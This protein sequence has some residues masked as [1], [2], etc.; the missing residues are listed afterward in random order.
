MIDVIQTQ[1]A[2]NA[3]CGEATQMP[4]V[5]FDTEFERIRTYY[6]RLCLIQMSTPDVTVCVDPLAELDFSPLFELLSNPGVIK[7]FHAARQDLEVLHT[8]FG[9]SISSIFDT[10]IAAQLCGY[11][12]QIAYAELAKNVCEIDLPKQYTRT[13]WSRRPLS[14]AEVKYALDDARYLGP[15]YL[16]LK[17]RLERLGRGGWVRE[18]CEW[19]TSP[20]ILASSPAGAIKKIQSGSRGLPRIEQ[21]VAYQ[22]ALWREGTAQSQ[23]R[24]REWILNSKAL[25]AI[26]AKLPTN[27]ADLKSI[28]GLSVSDRSRWSSAI[29]STVK[30]GTKRAVEYQPLAAPVR[31]TLEQKRKERLLWERLKV[32]CETGNIPMGAVAAR[33]DIRKLARGECEI[34]LMKGWRRQFA[35]RDLFELAAHEE[36]GYTC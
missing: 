13:D 9:I 6:P 18:D 27:T 11:R 1:E 12:Q 14:R 25:F 19:L 7:I 8:A 32:I 2:F 16:N 35:G 31:P 5:G 24:P 10:Q 29:L 33:K 36:P 34:R 15:I 28:S 22:L 23:N 4:W 17:R 20:A 30:A 3:R 21:S 26:A